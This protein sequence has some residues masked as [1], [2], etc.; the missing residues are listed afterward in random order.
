ML[1]FKNTLTVQLPDPNKPYLLFTDA[2]KYCYSG[3]LTQPSTDESSEALVQLIKGND[4]FTSIHSQTQEKCNTWGL[5]AMIIPRNV[6]LQ[7]IKDIAN[8]LADSI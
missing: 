5:E 8:I 6:K 4:P 1:T 2:S 7:H 3:V